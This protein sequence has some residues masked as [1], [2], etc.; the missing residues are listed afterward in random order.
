MP[1]LN[2]FGLLKKLKQ[3][4]DTNS[5]PV[6]AISAAVMKEEQEEIEKAGFSAILNKPFEI[7]EFYAILVKFLRYNIE[8]PVPVTQETYGF[9]EASLSPKQIIELI[10]ILEGE[11]MH[12]WNGFKEHQPMEEVEVF[13]N[14]LIKLYEQFPYPNLKSYGMQLKNAVSEFDIVNLLKYIDNYTQLIDMLKKEIK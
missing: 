1:Q 8:G 13:A 11:L 7:H 12:I 6:V 3:N 10:E 4:K 5:L 2:G 14:K 9:I